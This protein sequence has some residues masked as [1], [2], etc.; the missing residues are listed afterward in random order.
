MAKLVTKLKSASGKNASYISSELIPVCIGLRDREY[1]Y[2]LYTTVGP[3]GWGGG[4]VLWISSDWDD[5]RIFWGLKF[6]IL[7]FLGV[8]KFGKYFLGWLDL[9]MFF[10]GYYWSRQSVLSCL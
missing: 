5:R 4:G 2:F 6:S 8:G 10:G 3:R 7:G 1:F 9:R